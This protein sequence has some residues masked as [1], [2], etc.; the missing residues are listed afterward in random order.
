[1]NIFTEVF[2]IQS[3]IHISFDE[4]FSKLNNFHIVSVKEYDDLIDFILYNIDKQPKNKDSQEELDYICYALIMFHSRI[5]KML[6]VSTKFS[7]S[8]FIGELKQKLSPSFCE[9]ELLNEKSLTVSGT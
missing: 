8:Y 4:F 1:M 6:S 7:L 9:K 5:S 2:S 3:Q